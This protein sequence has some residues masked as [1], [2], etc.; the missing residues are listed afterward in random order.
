MAMGVRKLGMAWMVI[1]ILLINKLVGL[2]CARRQHPFALRPVPGTGSLVECCWRLMFHPRAIEAGERPPVPRHG[3]RQAGSDPCVE[4]PAATACPAI[5]P[6]RGRRGNEEI[7]EAFVRLAHGRNE[8]GFAAVSDVGASV[9][10]MPALPQVKFDAARGCAA[11]RASRAA[12]SSRER[13]SARDEFG[14]REKGPAPVRCGCP[15]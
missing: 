15:W 13:C 11:G 4:G 1:Q 10:R 6:D 3:W 7:R 12:V 5:A 9:E 14:V 8:A 2:A